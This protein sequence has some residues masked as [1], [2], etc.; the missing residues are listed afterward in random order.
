MKMLIFALDDEP[1]ALNILCRAIAEAEPGAELRKFDS[2]AE[3]LN[4]A[5]TGAAPDVLFT[6]ATMPGIDGVELAKRLKL[7]YP[8]L[9]VVFA[10]GYDD[11]MRDALS[12]HASGYLKK[13]VT[14]EDVRVELD[15]LRRPVAPPRKRVR[16][17]TFGNF[18]AFIDEKPVIFAREKTKEYLAYLVD[19]GTVCTN[20][21]IAA[22]LWEE[23]VTES[24]VRQLRK[25]VFDAFK[26]AGC[27]EVLIRKWN[28]QGIRTELVSCDYYDWK[29]GLPWALNA[30]QGE[31]MAQYSWAELT[32]AA[33]TGNR[34][35]PPILVAKKL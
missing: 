34:P 2:A 25:E 5:E 3:V 16:F 24:Y 10:T 30:Y 29:R 9:N 32:N 11:Y 13:P 18:E 31:Y 35:P 22:A 1:K 4:A 17:Q 7:R 15:N 23:N 26:A 20:A 19:R 8:E 21:Q 14:A 33:L 28:R 12:L 6:D 27:E